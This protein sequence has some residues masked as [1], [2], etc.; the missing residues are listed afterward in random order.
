MAIIAV[1]PDLCYARGDTGPITIRF[2]DGSSNF[3]FT[4]WTALEL[5]VD[6][7]E[8][9]TDALTNVIA[10]TGTLTGTPTD[11]LVS[12]RPPSPAASDALTPT[13]GL[14]YDVQGLN[15]SA[16]KVTLLKGGDFQII[17]DINKS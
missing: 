3:D 5:T 11:G 10:F 17:Q 2:K 7:Q 1:G 16:E 14:F 6:T 12:F 9:P 4:G 13:E 8:N 15:A